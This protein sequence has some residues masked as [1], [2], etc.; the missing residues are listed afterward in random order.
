MQVMNGENVV[1]RVIPQFVRGTVAGTTLDATAGHPDR[2]TLDVMV[3]S[4]TLGHGSTAKFTRPDDQR[5]FEHV[6]AFE[7]LDQG[8]SSLVDQLGGIGNGSLDA[9]MMVPATVVELNEAN[10][11]FCQS[12]C[13]QAVGGKRSVTA[14]GTI[15]VQGLLGFLG[16][17]DQV[18]NAGLHPESHLVLADSRGNFRVGDGLVTELI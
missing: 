7:I 2:E 8:G 5:V 14:L 11:P 1:D 4:G 3:T 16:D 17:I 13:Q 10:T 12:A 6:S 15:E 18:R 9:T